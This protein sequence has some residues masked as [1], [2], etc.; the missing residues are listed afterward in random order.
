MAKLVCCRRS[1]EFF[2]SD[3]RSESNG[4]CAGAGNRPSWQPAG[5][6]LDLRAGT[7][8]FSCGPLVTPYDRGAELARWSIKRWHSEARMLIR[9][10]ISDAADAGNVV[11]AATI[12]R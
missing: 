8:Q 2:R 11:A 10:T 5:S 7:P 1:C 9:S 12:F 6:L 3:Q 4:W